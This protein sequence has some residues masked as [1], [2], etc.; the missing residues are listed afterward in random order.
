[1]HTLCTIFLGDNNACIEQGL[2]LGLIIFL[3]NKSLAI[4]F[5]ESYAF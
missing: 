3:D 5:V 1:M 4:F 2:K